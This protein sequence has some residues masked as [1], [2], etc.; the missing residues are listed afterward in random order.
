MDKLESNHDLSFNNNLSFLSQF[1]S[2][3]EYCECEQQIELSINFLTEKKPKSAI[4]IK[5]RQILT[6]WKKGIGNYNCH[7]FKYQENQL[8]EKS[9][10][11]LKKLSTETAWVSGLLALTSIGLVAEIAPIWSEVNQNLLLKLPLLKNAIRWQ[12][13]KARLFPLL[14]MSEIDSILFGRDDAGNGHNKKLNT[15]NDENHNLEI[16]SPITL[17][18]NQQKWL[19]YP[20]KT[21][22]SLMA[23][24]PLQNQPSVAGFSAFLSTLDMTNPS[25]ESN[26]N[27]FAVFDRHELPYSPLDSVT[28]HLDD[29]LMA[30]PKAVYTP[31]LPKVKF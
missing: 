13:S 30:T 15:I 25:Q 28:Y 22:G 5:I 16:T 17:P 19:M 31:Y 14:E 7:L 2:G 27:Q 4:S 18:I 10:W 24:P 21:N 6:A 20:T 29:K 11:I 1:S 9:Q 8:L 3:I 23:I 12:R 26:L